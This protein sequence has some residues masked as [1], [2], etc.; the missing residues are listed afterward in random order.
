[1][2]VPAW[3]LAAIATVV[4]VELVDGLWRGIL[5]GRASALFFIAN[6]M[7]G[8]LGTAAALAVLRMAT[9]HVGNSH[10]GARWSFAMLGLLPVTAMG[11]LGIGGS[12]A[13]I[14]RGVKIVLTRPRV[15]RCSGGSCAITIVRYASSM[16]GSA[17]SRRETPAA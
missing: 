2:P 17:T 5:A 14:A 4:L 3:C 10:E 16:A 9:P 8:L 7:L 6:G 1:M 12:I 13:E 11:T 15:R